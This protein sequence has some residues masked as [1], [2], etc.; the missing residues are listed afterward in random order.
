MVRQGLDAGSG[1]V[2][3]GSEVRWAGKKRKEQESVIDSSPPL[4]EDE[5]LALI[6]QWENEPSPNPEYRGK[7]PADVGRMLFRNES[8]RNRGVT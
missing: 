4:S 5:R 8:H 3:R 6:E 2:D 1:A 7:T